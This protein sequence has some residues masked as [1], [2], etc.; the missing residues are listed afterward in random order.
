MRIWDTH[1]SPFFD[2]IKTE[3][4]LNC[5]EHSDYLEH[6]VLLLFETLAVFTMIIYHHNSI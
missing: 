2:I 6:M 5:V 1:I 3:E 4:E